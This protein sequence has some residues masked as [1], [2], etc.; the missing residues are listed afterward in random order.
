MH[1]MSY[2][3]QSAGYDALMSTIACAFILSYLF[4]SV[5]ML[6]RVSYL[7]DPEQSSDNNFEP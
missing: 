7:R 5:L 1:F 6:V 3:L 4:I 2:D